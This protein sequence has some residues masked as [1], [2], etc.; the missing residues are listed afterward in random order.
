MLPAARYP[1]LH[2]ATMAHFRLSNIERSGNSDQHPII[3]RNNIMDAC[4]AII[5]VSRDRKRRGMGWVQEEG[6]L[7][8][9]L[10][11]LQEE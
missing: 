7:D 11:I 8:A 5:P 10:T 4:S 2:G 1:L 3:G 9:S 6:I